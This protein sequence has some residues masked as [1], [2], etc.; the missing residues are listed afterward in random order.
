MKNF[1]LFMAFALALLTGCTTREVEYT[2]KWGFGFKDK[3]NYPK[4]T[5]YNLTLELSSGTR[6]FQAGAPGEL[7]FILCNKGKKPVRIPEWFKFDPNNLKV[8]CQI[9]LPGAEN[10][11]PDMWL[12]VSMPVKRPIWRYP[13]T[14]APGEKVFVS[15]NLDFLSKLIVSPGSERR[16][17]IKAKLNLKSVEVAAP[18]SYVTILPGKAPAIPEK[19]KTS[20]A[21]NNK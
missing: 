10:P 15:S 11:D 16:Y 5:N 2:K 9:W 14:L 12:D 3:V 7:T 17:F 6:R 21:L 20:P 4:L 1:T 18:V 13:I 19:G 8:Q